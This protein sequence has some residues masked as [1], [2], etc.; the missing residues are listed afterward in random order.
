MLLF[1]YSFSLLIVL[2][3][4]NPKYL[5]HKTRILSYYLERYLALL[6]QYLVQELFD[7]MHPAPCG[8]DTFILKLA[9][10]DLCTCSHQRVK[11]PQRYKEMVGGSIFQDEQL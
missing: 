3:F 4:E 2:L 5:F 6:F 7:F 1:T 9:R 8:I 10:N 11:P